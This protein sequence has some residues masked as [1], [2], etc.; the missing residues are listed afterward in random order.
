MVKVLNRDKIQRFFYLS[1]GASGSGGGSGS[2]DPS[3]L[4]GLVDLTSEQTITG[5]KTF[6]SQ[7]LSTVATG[8]APFSIASTT[9]VSNLNADLLDGVHA[10]G[11]FT[12]LVMDSNALSITIGG[13]T[14]SLTVGYA[15]KAAQD[16]EGNTIKTTY[17]KKT[18]ADTTYLKI[19]FFSRLFQAYNG[20]T[21][22]NPNDLTTT[23]DNIKA[24]FGFWTDFYLSALGS[25]GASTPSFS[26]A[27]LSD[28]DVTGVTNGQALVYN[29][30]SA[31]WV[32][33]TISSGVDMNVVWS[34]L[35]AA[36]NEQINASHLSTAFSS[37]LPLAGGTMSNTNT[38]TNLNADLLDGVHLAGTNSGGVTRSWGRGTYTSANQYFG[39]GNVVTIDPQGTG[40]LSAN[41]TILS[42]G[43]KN[44]RNTQLLVRWDEDGLFYRRIVDDLTYGDWKRFAFSSEIPTNNNQ[45][46]N[47]AGYITSSGSCSYSTTS[48]N[49]D[50][51]DGVHISGLF[52]ALAMDSNALSITIGGTTKTLTVGYATSTSNL[53]TSDTAQNANDC[54]ST[55]AGL[56]YYRTN[57]ND[58]PNNNDGFILQWA[59]GGG[60]LVGQQ[61]FLDDNATGVMK[62]RGKDVDGTFTN[63]W[64]IYTDKYH[65]NADYA[66]SAG[67][68]SSADY[69]TSAGSAGYAGYLSVYNKT[70]WGQTYWNSNGQPQN[71][72]GNIYLGDY[73]L[74][75][76]NGN[77]SYINAAYSNSQW[78]I[79]FKPGGTS[80]AEV[81]ESGF[82]CNGYVTALSDIRF[83][84][85]VDRMD[86]DVKRI[87]EMSIIKFLWNDRDEGGKL[88]VGCVAQEWESLLPWTVQEVNG[89]K[90]L[91][92]SVAAL[93][94]AVAIARKVESHEERIARLERELAKE[95]AL[96]SKESR[97]IGD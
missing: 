74:Y 47:G 13:T 52:T 79:G 5:Q 96:L 3:M 70:I 67:S 54:Y 12:A 26:L 50:L 84:N 48:G 19:A 34:A 92:Y 82:Y 57:G 75:I 85:V 80:I 14:K 41:D 22:V 61:L 1:G 42:L 83:K 91:D 58:M 40:C 56:H 43:D 23:I 66:T 37:Y 18:D 72:T 86:I 25:G 68:A 29:S 44:N 55:S 94:S 71:V 78:A 69:A 63:W 97:R 20:N 7:I 2:F 21:A 11:L 28:V 10:S 77:Y 31:K 16:D 15:T 64:Q 17:L 53:L 33:C 89:K 88:H 4:M 81:N 30:T 49:A 24:M 36:T 35:A 6:A 51:L 87:A 45:L 46:T 27:S 62:I 38:V 32:P 9:L 60:Y 76:G 65:P 73:A 39:N 59:Y 90:S 8:I 95:R 93:V